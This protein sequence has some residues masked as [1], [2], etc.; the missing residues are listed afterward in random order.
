MRTAR[1]VFEG[2]GS[3]PPLVRHDMLSTP[4]DPHAYKC[5]L[6]KVGVARCFGTHVQFILAVIPL[7][8][9]SAGVSAIDG[10]SPQAKHALRVIAMAVCKQAAITFD[11]AI[12]TPVDQ[13]CLVDLPELNGVLALLATDTLADTTPAAND[14]ISDAASLHESEQSGVGAEAKKSRS[15]GSP[16]LNGLM[17]H[18][19]EKKKN[20]LESEHE[21]K[22]EQK[23][24]EI[25]RLKKNMEK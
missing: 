22:M 14:T 8:M 4:V 1:R 10:C 12:Q 15:S 5:E 23:E 11:Q 6:A 3:L 18:A 24:E 2:S 16:D 9:A 21:E 19:W 13:L 17:K 25:A 20:I 7:E